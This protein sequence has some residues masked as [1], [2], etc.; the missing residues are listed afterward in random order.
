VRSPLWFVVAAA[1][2]VLGF[3]GAGLYVWPRLDAFNLHLTRVV[4]PGSQIVQ[5][6]R[7]GPYM[8]Y[9]ESLAFIDGQF[10]ESKMP[11]G[12]RITLSSVATGGPVELADPKSSFT[13]SEKGRGGHAILGFTISE[14]G[15]YRLAAS[16]PSGRTE[17]K[18][19]LAVGHGGS[20]FVF[21]VFRMVGVTMGLVFGGLGIAGVIVAITAVQRDKARRAAQSPLGG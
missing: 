1:F 13:Y 21:S 5:L 16:L 20:S 17:P 14:P 11:E 10:T 7:A 3:V 8:L 6:D 12:L 4:L 15:Q 19:V 9:H 2:A 18:F